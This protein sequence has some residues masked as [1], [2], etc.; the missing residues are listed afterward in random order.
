MQ[1]AVFS[2]F[3]ILFSLSFPGGCISQ[4]PESNVVKVVKTEDGFELLL[5]KKP[6]YIKGV[7]VGE[8]FGRSRENYLKLAK[9]MGANTVRTWGT[10]Q[11]TKRYL[12][13]AHRQGLYVD[14]G[15]WFNYVDAKK[16][17]SYVGDN[18]YLRKKEKET[19]DYVRRFKDHPGVL[20]WNLGNEVMIFTPDPK[21][22][23]AFCEFLE[24][25]IQKVHAIDPNHPVVYTSANV[26]EIP[27][28]K[29]YVPS[30]DIVGM[31]MYGSVIAADSRWQGLGFEI[32]YLITEFGPL[33]SW[34]LPKDRHGKVTEQSD[35]VKASQY[36]NHWNLIKE[37]KGKNIG[38]F[39]FHLGETTQ[40]SL[41]YWN[42]N[43]HEYKKESF[44]MMQKLFTGI[45][46]LNHAPKIQS[47]T[48]IPEKVK[49]G[50][51]FKAELRANDPEEDELS[52]DFKVST[53]EEGV[54]A[55]FVNEEVPVKVEV[56]GQQATLSTPSKPGIY[57]VYGF[58]RDGKSNSS[59]TS[60]T[61]KVE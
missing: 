37:R 18:D 8:G 28:L 50:A 14:A 3:L 5:N 59:V 7:G 22:K 33:G 4:I 21:E 54:L 36:K 6:F 34:D 26:A 53:T 58:A 46:D 23:I 9:T 51:S 32:P 42:L 49:A 13:E 44:V 38:G 1:K 35:Y 56:R 15:V 31:N 40:E 43:D 12:D 57:R 19:L 55:Y 27:Y 29:S 2:V 16:T 52:Y 41:T 10:D 39:A 30:L 47:F 25:M 45:D 11:G 17:V 48:G 60:R 61:F 24:K 20:L